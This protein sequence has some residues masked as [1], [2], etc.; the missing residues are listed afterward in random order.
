MLPDN[1]N[2]RESPLSPSESFDPSILVFAA[3][4]AFVVWK[5]WSVLGVRVDRENPAE[6]RTQGFGRRIGPVP[7]PAAPQRPGFAPAAAAVDPDRWRGLAEPA[8]KGWRG[9]DE[10]AGADRSFVA[11]AFVEGGKKAYEMIVEAFARGDRDTLHNLLAKDVFDGFATEISARER[12]GET[13]E[14]RVASIASALVDDAKIDH[15]KA[16]VTLRIAAKLETARRGR[17]GQIIEGDP[18]RPVDIVDLW[19]FARDLS[20]RDPNWKLVATETVH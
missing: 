13:A 20:S 1:P 2:D 18:T 3:L 5:L 19:T 16:Y 9:L 6:D 11:T 12:R 7:P 15:G 10:I 17:D 8:S 4:A 14:A